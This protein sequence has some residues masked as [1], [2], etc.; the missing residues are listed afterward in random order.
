VQVE[1]LRFPPRALQLHTGPPRLARQASDALHLSGQQGFN[2]SGAGKEKLELVHKDSKS[3]GNS[4]IGMQHE[5]HRA[6]DTEMHFG[7][8]GFRARCHEAMRSRI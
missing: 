3:A 8:R 7:V 1:L 4:I 5:A 6:Q 2:A